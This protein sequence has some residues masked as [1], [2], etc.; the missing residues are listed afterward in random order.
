M[1]LDESSQSR[2]DKS[3]H[4]HEASKRRTLRKT[5]E[6]VIQCDSIENSP[7]V[8]KNLVES[9]VSE[10]SKEETTASAL[11][12]SEVLKKCDDEPVNPKICKS[13]NLSFACLKNVFKFNTDY[14]L[15]LNFCNHRFTSRVGE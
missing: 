8:E 14:S 10:N 5:M 2:D 12:F 7:F 15:S 9:S 1:K 11:N 4:S 13:I 3:L 6:K